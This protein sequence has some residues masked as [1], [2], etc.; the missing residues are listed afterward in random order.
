MFT[1]LYSIYVYDV[2]VRKCNM[3]TRLF[4]HKTNPQ[5]S[6]LV[7]FQNDTCCVC[8]HWFSPCPFCCKRCKHVFEVWTEN[9]GH[10]SLIC[11]MKKI[12]CLDMFTSASNE[13][14]CHGWRMIGQVGHKCWIFT[15]T[16]CKKLV[17]N[18]TTHLKKNMRKSNLLSFHPE[19]WV[20][21]TNKR[22]ENIA[23]I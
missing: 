6:D 7:T 11:T 3:T 18:L 8:I 4:S 23:S 20:N 5:T 15:S 16:N 21:I 2:Q 17:S 19:F 1:Y 9:M 14:T 13:Q 22:F 12:W 10:Q